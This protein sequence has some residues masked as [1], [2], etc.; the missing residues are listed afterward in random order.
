MKNMNI[1]YECL[2]ARDD[3]YSQRNDASTFIP[4]LDE[5]TYNDV[6]QF[7][8]L[9]SNYQADPDDFEVQEQTLPDE[10][11]KKELRSHHNMMEISDELRVSGWIEPNSPNGFI[12]CKPNISKNKTGAQWRAT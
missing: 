4:I 1:R 6:E 8:T 12:P 9:S 11:G 2:D 10:L 7:A 3:F 5:E